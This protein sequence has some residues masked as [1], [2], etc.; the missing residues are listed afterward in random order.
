MDAKPSSYEEV[1]EKRVWKDVMGEEYQSIV[2]ND[3]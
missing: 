2:K 3:V 1:T